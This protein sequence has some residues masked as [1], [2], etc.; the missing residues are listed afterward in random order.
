M[1]R[2]QVRDADGERRQQELSDYGCVF[3]NQ[4]PVDPVKEF[5]GQRGH[6]KP[7]E[8]HTKPGQG[9]IQNRSSENSCSDREGQH[10][11]SPKGRRRREARADLGI[12]EKNAK[13]DRTQS[14]QDV[15]RERSR[16]LG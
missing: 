3:R 13:R 11:E 1:G 4:L 14:G 12:A 7:E 16:V 5:D 9:A 15:R 2:K 10:C 8:G 6:K